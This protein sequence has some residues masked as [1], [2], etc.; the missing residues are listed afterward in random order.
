MLSRQKPKTKQRKFIKKQVRNFPLMIVLGLVVV[1]L[2]FFTVFDFNG[3]TQHI[4]A[5]FE[6]PKKPPGKD[7]VGKEKK[8]AARKNFDQ[9]RKRKK[10]QKRKYKMRLAGKEARIPIISLKNK[11]GFAKSLSR[12]SIQTG[13]NFIT[14]LSR[15]MIK[16]AEIF[17]MLNHFKSLYTFRN[18]QP[19]D[20]FFFKK[21]S[22][23]KITYFEYQR[24]RGKTYIYDAR[25]SKPKV[26]KR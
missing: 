22:G 21:E 24:I 11:P 14:A 8:I 5:G 7:L 6:K 25:G 26:Y 18:V 2:V 19:G 15:N 1:N 12:G 17:K 23:R 4:I 10:A 3:K 13:E 20:T 9:D 16:R